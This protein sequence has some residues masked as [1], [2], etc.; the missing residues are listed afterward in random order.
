VRRGKLALLLIPFAP[1]LLGGCSKGAGTQATVAPSAGAT[2]WMAITGGSATPSPTPTI[3]YSSPAPFPTGFLP[4]GTITPVPTPSGTGDCAS[5]KFH[6]GQ[7][8]SAT[9]VAGPT[10]ATVTWYNP[11]G[12]DLV[13][14]RLTAI[15]E[16]QLSVGEQRDIGWT[17]IKPGSG[18]GFMS[19]PVT[20]LDRQTSYVFSVDAVFTKLGKDGT[21]ASTIARSIPTTTS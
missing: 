8:N 1:L 18:C 15:A 9:V 13:E 7:I 20:G 4:I 10:S 12:S 14:Y 16:H 21:W 6:P 19:A 11:G 5:I 17:V 2:P 3:S